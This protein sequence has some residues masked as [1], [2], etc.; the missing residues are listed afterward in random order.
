MSDNSRFISASMGNIHL[1]IVGEILNHLKHLL[2]LKFST[3]PHLQIY[4][5][6]AY[7]DL[8]SK[9]FIAALFATADY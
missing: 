2:D 6:K 7:Q 1:H 5:T 9:M 4:S 3:V 8:N